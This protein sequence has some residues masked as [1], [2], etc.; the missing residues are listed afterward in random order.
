MLR[1]ASLLTEF[2]AEGFGSSEPEEANCS[3]CYAVQVKERRS[4]SCVQKGGANNYCARGDRLG[5]TCGTPAYG[6]AQIDDACTGG[7]ANRQV[8]AGAGGMGND[9]INRDHKRAE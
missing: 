3:W 9:G 8:D 6:A 1:V 4:P 2:D 7:I 5:C